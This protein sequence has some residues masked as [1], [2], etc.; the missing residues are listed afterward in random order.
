[1]L[2]EQSVIVL[3]TILSI[4]IPTMG[5]KL[6]S[7]RFEPGEHNNQGY[8]YGQGDTYYVERHTFPAKGHTSLLHS[9]ISGL[10]KTISPTSSDRQGVAGITSAI[11]AA[12]IP[13]A[14]VAIGGVMRE[15]ILSA[16][17][18]TTT[19]TA[20]TTTVPDYCSGV[21]CAVTGVS[22]TCDTT[23]GECKC[24]TSGACGGNILAPRCKATGATN[25]GCTDSNTPCSGG[26]N[27][28]YCVVTAN[29][30]QATASDASGTA[31]KACT[32]LTKAV[33]CT[34]PGSTNCALG[35]CG[36]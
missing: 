4:S 36:A 32:I 3:V 20:A 21:E 18:T 11:Q 27:E 15:Q 5:D 19:T 17:T 29:S 24:G 25:C 13:I 1:M 12:A 2:L 22:D 28:K 31:C 14:A 6:I 9:F 30:V 23:T 7:P 26:T 10:R 8:G 16:L 33:D 35:S 34:T